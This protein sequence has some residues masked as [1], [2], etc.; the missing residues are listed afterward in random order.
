[1]VDQLIKNIRPL[2]GRN[3]VGKPLQLGHRV[4]GVLPIQLANQHIFIG[5]KLVQR[6]NGY[7]GP[8]RHLVERKRL[9]PHINKHAPGG[10]EYAGILRPG[11]LLRRPPARLKNL[12]RRIQIQ[13]ITAH[14]QT[15]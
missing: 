5:K 14:H 8:L 15:S 2:Q 12:L 1:M 10:C 3:L 6:A 7:L 13:V 9:K 11:S 4:G